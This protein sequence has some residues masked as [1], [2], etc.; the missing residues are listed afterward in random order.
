MANDNQSPSDSL[1]QVD[2][3]GDAQS[4]LLGEWF[5]YNLCVDFPTMDEDRNIVVEMFTNDPDNGL[6]IFFD[7]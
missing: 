1:F 5:K 7:I 6:W 4:L 2:G 3:Q